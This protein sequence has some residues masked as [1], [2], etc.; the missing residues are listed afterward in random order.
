[1]GWDSVISIASPYTLDVQ[2]LNPGGGRS[3]TSIGTGPGAHPPPVQWLLGLFPRGKA[4]GAW[5]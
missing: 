5:H 1:V 4:A 2:E 3:S